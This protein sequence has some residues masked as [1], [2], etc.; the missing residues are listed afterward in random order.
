MIKSFIL[1][2]LM[3][4]VAL[5]PLATLGQVASDDQAVVTYNKD[6]F[7]KY[8][9]VT[10]LDML[11]RV[12]GVQAIID[13]NKA[14]SRNSSSNSG[15]KAERGFGSGGDQILIN[16]KRLS[17]KSNSISDT[18]SRIS[19]STVQRVEIIRGASSDLDVQSQGLVVNIV[20][21][22]GAD[23]SSTFWNVGGRYS[24]TY[25]FSPDI[26]MSHNGSKGRFDY[27]FGGSYKKGQHIEHRTDEVFTPANV[28]TG[29]ATRNTN[30]IF[31]TFKFNGNLTYNAENGDEFRLNGQ[32]E[33]AKYEKL[34][35]RTSTALNQAQQNQY[36]GEGQTSSK[37]EFGGDYTKKIDN[38]GTWK[39]LFI[40]NRDRIDKQENY[41]V[42]NV[43]NFRNDQFRVKQE[44]ILR[45]SQINKLLSLA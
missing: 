44:K 32:F 42:S 26:L 5:V 41:L 37:W 19:A 39:T 30:N 4:T 23:T 40:A 16:N 34:E 1:Q 35:P 3:S 25:D 7:I 9:P 36:W 31:K 11:Q 10:L 14:Q 33:P 18:L 21:A 6:Y 13:K 27:I 15:G 22:E 2:L 17:G 12:P 8:D 29:A 45:T 38:V 28:F 43:P 24:E 20:M